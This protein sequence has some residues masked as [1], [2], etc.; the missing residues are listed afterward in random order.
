MPPEIEPIELRALNELVYCERLY[1]LMYVQRLFETS[2][3]T[4]EGKKKHEKRKENSPKNLL[5]GAEISNTTLYSKCGKLC[6]RV[7]SIKSEDEQYIPIEDK[8]G[9]V[10]EYPLEKTLFDVELPKINVWDNDLAQIA[11]QMY[12]LRS[13]GHECNLGKVYYR[14]S[15]RLVDVTYESALD[16]FVTRLINKAN[17]LKHY[18]KMPEPLVDSE[19]CVKCSLN[20]ICLPDEQNFIVKK[21]D[22]PRRLYPGRADG[23]ILYVISNGGKVSKEGD[24]FSIWTPDEGGSRVPVKDVE[25]IC[26][27]GNVQITTQAIREMIRHEG[28]I[29]YFS[30]SGYLEG[31]TSGIVTKNISLRQKQ[32]AD[33]NVSDIQLDL[34]K[35]IVEAKIENQRTLLR[36]NGKDDLEEV[37]KFLKKTSK[38]IDDTDNLDSLR[39]FEGIA[40]QKYWG[41]FRTMLNDSSEFDITGRNKRPPKDEINAMLSYGYSLLTRDFSAALAAVGFDYMFGFYHAV[42]AG[43]PAFSLDMMEPYRPL[44]VDSTILRLVNEKQISKEDFVVFDGGVYMSQ[45]AKKKLLT[46]Y[47]RRVDEMITHPKFGYRLSYRRMFMLESK[48]LAKYLTGEL[49]EY[50]PLTT[51]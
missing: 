45:T 16:T 35:K 46:A 39:G 47:E 23:G 34:S 6:G 20:F 44:V 50:L 33:F 40:A 12:L 21:T 42:V 19:K 48:L 32:F 5:E 28:T 7:D 10:P 3:D 37:L 29:S 22:E 31:M 41:N 38:Q 24:N 43:R 9:K 51:R 49:P 11:G 15:N 13:N 26:L 18:E 36:R 27:F 4:L 1:Y 8:N 25:H 2:V 14:A 30:A 17:E